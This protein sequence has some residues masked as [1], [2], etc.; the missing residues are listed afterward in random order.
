MTED[1]RLQQAL[2]AYDLGTVR[3]VYHHAG[4]AAKTWRVETDRGSWLLRTR[5]S[6][7]SSDELI[8]FDHG[9]RAHMVRRGVPTAEPVPNQAGTPFVRIGE[10][11]MEVYRLLPGRSIGK[12]G[13]REIAAAARLLAQFH[14]AG[15][16]YRAEVPPVAQYRTLG[17]ATATTRM[18]SPELLGQVYTRLDREAGRRFPRVRAVARRWL[19][20]LRE[21]F[22]DAAYQSLPQTLTHGDF[23]LANL[24]FAPDGNVCG[25][26][27]FDWS[28]RGP[29]VRDLADGLFFVAGRRRTPLQAGSIWS[30]TEAVELLPPRCA[31]WL[32]S[33]TAIN[34]LTPGEWNA[35]PLALA[36]RWLSVRVE[37]TAKVTPEDR[38]RFAFGNLIPPLR[39]LDAHWAEVQNRLMPD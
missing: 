22:S 15:E 17:I 6:R 21:E 26:F 14:Q 4:T 23:T 9:L 29:R 31:V 1:E 13:I 8:A 35:I 5:G 11:A 32:G 19:D 27:D 33:Y 2:A 24:L 3:S 10:T 28:R 25:V 38:L 7:T 36:A 30:L 18:E 20:R 37:G 16:D 12:A 34:P 39:W